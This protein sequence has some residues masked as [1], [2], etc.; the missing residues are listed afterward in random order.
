MKNIESAKSQRTTNCEKNFSLHALHGTNTDHIDLKLANILSRLNVIN[1]KKAV[2][3]EQSEQS[4]VKRENL[5]RS[6]E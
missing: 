1:E 5:N 2:V 6:Y 3:D 4:K